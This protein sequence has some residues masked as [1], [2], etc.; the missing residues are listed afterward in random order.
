MDD[1]HI[2]PHKSGQ[3]LDMDDRLDKEAVQR[4]QEGLDALDHLFPAH[5]PHAAWF[6][7]QI[8]A[9]QS[10]QRSQLLGDLLKL[11]VA[12]L[13]LL[14]LLFLTAASLPAAFLTIQ[15]LAVVVPVAWLILRKRVSSHEA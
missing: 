15:L 1:K 14:A 10:K 3:N 6:D 5:Q 8:A 13:V 11:W 9:T 2:M 7:E 4:L 12:A